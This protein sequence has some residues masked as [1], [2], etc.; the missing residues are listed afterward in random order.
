MDR[1]AV[2]NG[3]PGA[4]LGL[5]P[6]L[7]GLEEGTAS[8]SHRV[9]QASLQQP[10]SQARK[11]T[12]ETHFTEEPLEAQ[13]RQGLSMVLWVESELPLSSLSPNQMD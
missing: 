9:L 12:A 1:A 3:T 6:L 7:R 11:D 10:V 13:E 8:E 2:S 5:L 4:S